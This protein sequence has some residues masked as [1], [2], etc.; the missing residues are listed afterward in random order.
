MQGTDSTAAFGPSGNLLL[1]ALRP[2]DYHRLAPHLEAVPLSSG[3]VVSLPHA[4][5]PTTAVVSLL[6]AAG[7][8]PSEEVAVMGKEGLIGISTF[9]EHSA[10]SAAPPRHAVVQHA[11]LAWRLPGSLLAEHFNTHPELQRLLLRF[12]QALITQIA[13][14]AVCSRHH[15]VAKQLCRWLLLRLDRLAGCEIPATHERIAHLLGVRR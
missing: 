14:T 11:G 4:Y 2:S 12:T 9:L 5:F 13:Q 7:N 10:G 6:T 15:R 8:A 3:Q 1:D